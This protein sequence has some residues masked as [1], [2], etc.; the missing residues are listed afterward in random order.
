MDLYFFSV[1]AIS[2]KIFSYLLPYETED[3]E[4]GRV[5]GREKKLSMKYKYLDVGV[6]QQNM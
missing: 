3:S 1:D 2:K 4:E 6:M 5:E